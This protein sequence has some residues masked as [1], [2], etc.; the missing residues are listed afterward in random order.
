MKRLFSILSVVALLTSAAF[1]QE[2]AKKGVV[3][4]GGNV[5]FTSITAIADG[6]SA[7]NSTT[8]FQIS[9][10]VGYFVMDGLEIG[11]D[12][13]E[14]GYAG[15]SATSGLTTLSE[16]SYTMTMVGIWAFG[17]Y[18]FLTGGNAFPYLQALVGYTSESETGSPG[19]SGLSYGF[20][21]GAKFKLTGGLLLNA[22]ISY[23]FYTYNPSGATNR[24]GLNVLGIGAGFSGFFGK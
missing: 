21:G 19:A 11:I 22:G 15:T 13:L 16:G 4:L 17:A 7:S 8:I 5:G 9:P 20:A 1:A 12:P 14:L 24:F 23:K 10:T 18:H 6:K 3:E 2:F